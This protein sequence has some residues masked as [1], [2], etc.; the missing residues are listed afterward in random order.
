[1]AGRSANVR[2][3]RRVRETYSPRSACAREKFRSYIARDAAGGLYVRIVVPCSTDSIR[4]IL[5]RML[6]DPSWQ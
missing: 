2:L 6:R 1:M 3:P 5:E 4:Q